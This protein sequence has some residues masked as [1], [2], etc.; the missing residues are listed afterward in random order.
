MNDAVDLATCLRQRLLETGTDWREHASYLAETDYDVLRVAIKLRALIAHEE[1]MP[2]EDR[3]VSESYAVLRHQAVPLS[4]DADVHAPFL[5]LRPRTRTR[6]RTR[7]CKLVTLLVHGHRIPLSLLSDVASTCAKKN[8]P[9]SGAHDQTKSPLI[10]GCVRTS[11]F[12]RHAAAR[13]PKFTVGAPGA[14][15]DRDGREAR[16]PIRR[17]GFGS[18][19]RRRSRTDRAVGYTTALF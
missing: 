19:E 4:D 6:K 12:R 5:V 9:F 15:A 3:L 18:T 13:L 10:E 7:A 8:E 17:M 14:A 16:D 11:F 1:A 2:Q